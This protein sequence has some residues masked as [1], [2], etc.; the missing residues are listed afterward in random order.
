MET[1][2]GVR[3]RRRRPRVLLLVAVLASAAGPRIQCRAQQQT[4]CGSATPLRVED[5][6][7]A[8]ALDTAVDC[9]DGG[10][11]EAVWAGIVTLDAPISVGS[12]TSLSITGEDRLAEVKGG[13]QVRLFTVASSAG[14]ALT[15]LRLSG[16][17][18]AS[19]G[20]IHATAATVTLDGCVF[21]ENEA[22]SGDGGAVW[23]AG[24]ELTIVSGEFLG[25]TADGNG[26]AVLAVDDTVVIQGGTRFEENR[27]TGGGGLYC[28]GAE[29]STSGA[30][31]S[32]SLSEA[33][34]RFNNASSEVILDYDTVVAP[35]V[36]LYG[37]GGAAFYRGAVDMTDSVFE[38]NYAQLS[39][40][41]VYGGKDS[42]MAI[43]GCRF[44]E[45]FTPGYGG[46]MAASSA[47]LGGG[48]LVT[49][50][51]AEAN[52][53]GVSSAFFLV[54]VYGWIRF[55]FSGLMWLAILWRWF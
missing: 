13:S 27:A 40:G 45:N 4:A 15:N 34:F 39:G 6:A 37:G 47:T 52:G 29:N 2:Q 33:V 14:L 22:T 49:N 11:V 54:D 24:G 12:G 42:D 9:A 31:A 51:S 26:G 36:T 1:F 44:E 8:R 5:L 10:A 41:G 35:W 21:E 19:G 48:T 23:A 53:A 25:N 7:G 30:A 16:G 46:A 32:C 17:A 28:G 50:N 18:A 20:A 38:F 3:G 43:E 55:H